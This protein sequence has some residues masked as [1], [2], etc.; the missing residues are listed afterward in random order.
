MNKPKVYIIESVSKNDLKRNFMEGKALSE[1][2]KLST[3]KSEYYLITKK[4]KF[5]DAFESI[6]ND[7]I[8][9]DP[10]KEN[11]RPYIHI[12]AHGNEKG[13][14]LTDGTFISWEELENCLNIINNAPELIN[15]DQEFGKYSTI[16][17]CLSSC[18]GLNLESILFNNIMSPFA[19]LIASKEA[20]PWSDS[21][22]AYIT[23]YHHSIEHDNVGS[24]AIEAMKIASKNNSF[25]YTFG[26]EFRKLIKRAKKKFKYSLFEKIKKILKF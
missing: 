12:S 10:S 25:D 24:P 13:I 19:V 17:L 1:Y 2:F 23:F 4:E 11:P 6:K 15:E 9:I 8:A 7:L 20:I 26:S 16:T 14:G 3:I 18:K 5:I 21:L 22:T